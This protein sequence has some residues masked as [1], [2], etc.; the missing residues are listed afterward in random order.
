MTDRLVARGVSPSRADTVYNWADEEYARPRGIYPLAN[1]GFD[2]RFNLVF[3]GSFGRVQGLE[4]LV[5]GR[6]CRG[7]SGSEAAAHTHR[8]RSGARPL[9]R[10]RG[11]LGSDHVQL[12][13]AVPQSEIG[14]VFH[15]ADVLVAHLVDAPVFEVTVPSKLQFYMAMGKPVLFG[16]QGEAARIIRESGAGVVTTP[17][18][19]E[20]MARRWWTSLPCHPRALISWGLGLRTRTGATTPA[21]LLWRGSAPRWSGRWRPS[22][23]G[24]VGWLTLRA[25]DCSTCSSAHHFLPSWLFH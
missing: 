25:S 24:F 9:G 13:P 19:V 4:T 3:G 21:M 7:P 17:G 2:G 11:P 18:S 23:R 14:D 8:R 5:R 6:P 10:S 16:G 1:L 22:R 12:L 15:A 20:E